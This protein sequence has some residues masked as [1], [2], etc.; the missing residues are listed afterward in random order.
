[1]VFGEDAWGAD[2][3]MLLA[4]PGFRPFLW[5]R[6]DSLHLGPGGLEKPLLGCPQGVGLGEVQHQH[7]REGPVR[8]TGAKHT[9]ELHCLLLV[10]KRI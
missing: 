2:Q 10:N 8:H 7:Y 1:M 3:A 5:R 9:L 4:G 6:T